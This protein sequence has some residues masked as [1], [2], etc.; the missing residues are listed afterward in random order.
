MTENVGSGLAPLGDR[1]ADQYTRA[2][3]D[4]SAGGV[5]TALDSMLSE[6]ARD[7]PS[8]P[9]R[10]QGSP[11]SCSV[12]YSSP[13]PVEAGS[14]AKPRTIGLGAAALLSIGGA[15]GGAWLYARWHRNRNKP[16][17]R[18]RRGAKDVASHIGAR[19]P[20]VDDLPRGAAPMSGAATALLLTGLLASRALQ[21]GSDNRA[22]D[23]RD[24]ASELLRNS[25]REAQGHGRDAIERRRSA[26]DRGRELADRSSEL[27]DLARDVVDRGRVPLH[28]GPH[29]PAFLGLGLGGLS[30]LA[31]GCY[32]V[33][34]ILRGNI[35]A[36]GAWQAA[37]IAS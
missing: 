32:L 2:T 7:A 23:L 11:P 1:F 31:G 15:A 37:H 12:D 20:D 8:I 16:I 36:P 18:L 26:A 19:I 34:R 14:L 13:V 10:S 24:Q 5:A 3:G 21:R 9:T 28:A 33:W 22:D 4:L 29:K 6:P 35:G 27:A 17:N 30:I 25:V